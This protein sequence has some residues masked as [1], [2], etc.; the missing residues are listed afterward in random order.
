MRFEIAMW[1]HFY[2]NCD[3]LKYIEQEMA[4]KRGRELGVVEEEV[5]APEDDLYITP[6]HLKVCSFL[7]P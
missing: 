2:W 1:N 6:D 3:R 5:K 4:K 7:K